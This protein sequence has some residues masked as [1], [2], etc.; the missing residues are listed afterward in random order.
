VRNARGVSALMVLGG[1]LIALTVVWGTSRPTEKLTV[2][3]RLRPGR[4]STSEQLVDQSDRVEPP[5][6]VNVNAADATGKP[7]RDLRVVSVVLSVVDEGGAAVDG[8]SVEIRGVSP[9]EPEPV[10]R[11]VTKRDGTCVC[12][13]LRSPGTYRVRATHASHGSTGW[14]EFE[15]PG[16]DSIRLEFKAGTT[17][18]GRVRDHST[19]DVVVGAKVSVGARGPLSTVTGALGQFV[20]RGMRGREAHERTLCVTAAGYA[21]EVVV[22]RDQT[23]LEVE[24]R[25]GVALEGRVVSPDG[26]AIQDAQVIVTVLAKTSHISLVPVATAGSGKFV[27]SSLRRGA[28]HR[29]VI[30]SE[31]WGQRVFDIAIPET[32]EDV[33]NIGDLALLPSCR[34]G[35]IVSGVGGEPMVGATVQ[36]FGTI[37]TLGGTTGESEA[38]L[39]GVRSDEKGQFLFSRLQPGRFVVCGLHPDGRN[40]RVVVELGDAR[41]VLDLEL[42]FAASRGFE[43]RIE[44]DRGLSVPGVPVRVWT[45]VSSYT[46][47]TDRDGRVMISVDGR[48][49]RI[50]AYLREGFARP[51]EVRRLSPTD[52]KAEFRVIRAG[53]IKGKVIADD[54]RGVAGAMVT[55]YAG[56]HAVSTVRCGSDGCFEISAQSGMTTDLSAHA[57]AGWGVAYGVPAGISGV[58]ITVGPVPAD[59]DME[60]VVM[61]PEGCPVGG[62]RVTC[63]KSSGRTDE[64]GALVLSGLPAM[65]VWVVV[66]QAGVLESQ[67]WLAPA[68]KLLLPGTGR[69]VLRCVPGRLVKVEVLGSDGGRVAGASVSIGRLAEQCPPR[70]GQTG[71]DG[72]AHILVPKEGEGPFKVEATV[73][74]EQGVKRGAAYIGVGVNQT[75]VRLR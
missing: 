74:T 40:K 51:V 26:G 38:L 29:V 39:H 13:G 67:G 54:G 11:L 47:V 32:S 72:I 70:T 30:E 33:L 57:E 60:C 25:S 41:E 59:R 71:A 49:S 75:T 69:T 44:D 36:L 19:G 22:V 61:D 28:S 63:H 73:P 42:M 43:V 53:S 21:V 14:T 10:R 23:F 1:L 2:A 8:A 9:A 48:P 6:N 7:A 52:T 37:P 5:T 12:D 18:R 24:L 31:G 66:A 64:H 50:M 45:D 58:T 68:P 46:G 3:E 62:V 65:G 27:K 56:G 15:E 17:L 55:A 20:L 4:A 35:G 16:I 34:I